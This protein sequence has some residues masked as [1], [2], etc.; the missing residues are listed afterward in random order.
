LSG[1]VGAYLNRNRFNN[2][3]ILFL[4]VN[5]PSASRRAIMGRRLMIVPHPQ[6]L[7]RSSNLNLSPGAFCDY[8]IP[9]FQPIRYL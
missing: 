7:A 2:N 1:L 3:N 6:K 9:S 5:E 4:E 8:G